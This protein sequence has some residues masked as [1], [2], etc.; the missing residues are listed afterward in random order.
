MSHSFGTFSKACELKN[1]NVK[2][3]E[4]YSKVKTGKSPQ[5]VPQDAWYLPRILHPRYVPGFVFQFVRFR[6]CAH[7]K[8][9]FKA[10]SM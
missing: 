2:M 8:V 10:K 3:Y 5:H 1:T 6:F 7:L 4:H 9:Y